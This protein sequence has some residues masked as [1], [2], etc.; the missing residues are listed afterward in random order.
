MSEFGTGTGGWV[1][2]RWRWRVGFWI[3]HRDRA[4]AIVGSFTVIQAHSMG[5]C[6]RGRE[7][8]CTF[9]LACHTCLLPLPF[10][11]PTIRTV[12]SVLTAV[13]IESQCSKKFQSL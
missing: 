11:L 6:K 7:Q 3:G 8:H 13:S 9:A 5:P 4:C 12:G 2:E 1:E 10:P